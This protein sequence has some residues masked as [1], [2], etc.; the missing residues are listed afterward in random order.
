[1]EEFTPQHLPEI[2]NDSSIENVF[3]VGLRTHQ[4]YRVVLFGLFFVTYTVTLTCNLLIILLVFFTKLSHSPM[5]VLLSNLSLSEILFT[6]N[7]IPPMLYILLRNGAIFSLAGCFMQFFLFGIFAVTESFL[8]SAMSYD[9][10]LAICKPLH[11]TLIMGPRLC[12]CL[13]LV[14]W[15][16][17]FLI[18]SITIGA[19]NTLYFCKDNIIDHFYC[20]F[21]PIVKL[22]CSDSTNVKMVVSFFSS[23]ASVIP[24]IIIMATY[25]FI[26]RAITRISS[27]KGKEKAFSTCS[28]HLGVV[29]TYYVTL[30]MVYVVSPGKFVTMNKVLSLLYTVVTPLV[31]PFIYTLRNQE[32]NAAIRRTLSSGMKFRFEPFMSS[33]QT[34]RVRGPQIR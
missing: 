10:F 5:Y 33:K 13:I 7:I 31:N 19:L 17:A 30:I 6:S 24:F 18:M 3:I 4:S 9:R 11:Y 15:A 22:S 8:L 14:C 12:V 23:S 2:R 29:S 1:M 32:I 16:L 27:S 20:D 34:L 21:I 26:I 28:S 25:V